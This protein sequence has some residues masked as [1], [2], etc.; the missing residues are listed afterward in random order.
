MNL[1]VMLWRVDSAPAL[2]YSTMVLGWNLGWSALGEKQ[3]ALKGVSSYVNLRASVH[4]EGEY[5]E[6]GSAAFFN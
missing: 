1:Q 6:L 2:K 4:W 3:S 5:T